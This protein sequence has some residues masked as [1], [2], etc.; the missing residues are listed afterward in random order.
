MC[1]FLQL[2][3]SYDDYDGTLNVHVIQARNLVPKIKLA[4]TDPLVKIF[5]LPYKWWVGVLTIINTICFWV[6]I[7]NTSFEFSILFV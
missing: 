4:Y 5:L 7:C 3:L 1:V 2:Q 6:I